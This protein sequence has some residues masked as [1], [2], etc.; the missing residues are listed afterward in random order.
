M[1]NITL[2]A[3]FDPDFLVDRL[4]GYMAD[5]EDEEVLQKIADKFLEEIT[6]WREDNKTIMT[7]NADMKAYLSRVG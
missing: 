6:S 1:K 5:M 3:N 2:E 4:F 7:I